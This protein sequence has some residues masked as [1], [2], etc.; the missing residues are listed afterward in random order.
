MSED[1]D[2]QIG[3]KVYFV[4]KDTDSEI[5]GYICEDLGNGV[6]KVKIREGRSFGFF[7]TERLTWIDPPNWES[8]EEN[9][10][11]YGLNK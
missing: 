2:F 7:P 8:L 10:E 4:E 9:L 5:E 3:D 1:K 6:W 11:K